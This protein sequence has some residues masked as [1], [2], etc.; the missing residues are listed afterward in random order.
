MKT[1]ILFA[2]LGLITAFGGVHAMAQDDS[3]ITD[4]VVELNETVSD[5]GFVHP[6]VG[7]SAEGLSVMRDMVK[8]GVSPW[9]DYFEGLRQTSYSKLDAP[10]KKQT[11]IENDGGINS[12]CTDAQTAWTQAI[13]YVVTGNEEYRKIPVELI[14]W[15]GE[16][17]DFFPKYFS[18]S[19]IKIGKYVHTMCAA[20]EII[21]YTEPEDESLK[22]TDS[23]IDAL[24]DN[25]ISAIVSGAQ[26][27]NN[28]YFMNQHSYAVQGYLASAVLGDNKD[29]YAD[30]I[31]MTTVNNS[32]TNKPRNGAIDAVI[33][34][35]TE[36]AVTGEAVTPHLQLVEMGRDQAHA[37][38]NT[39]NLLLM[40][41]TADIQ[42]TLVDEDTGLISENGV[43]VR[44]FGGDKIIKG[45]QQWVQFN[46]GYRFE[47]TPVWAENEGDKQVIYRDIADEYRGRLLG[48]SLPS[49]YLSYK[50]LGYDLENDYPYITYAFNK[51]WEADRDRVLSGTYIETLHNYS[52]DFWTNLGKDAAISEPDPERAEK[53]LKTDIEEY[54]GTPSNIIEFENRWIDL[55]ELGTDELSYP[56]G[57]DDKPIEDITEDNREF[58]RV[59]VGNTPRS[60]VI[61]STEGMPKNKIGFMVRSEG[62]AKINIHNGEDYEKYPTIQTINIPDTN[63]EWRYVI[64][65]YSEQAVSDSQR[66]S[67]W[68]F[69]IEGSGAV[70]DFDYINTNEEDIKPIEIITTYPTDVVAA[71][72]GLTITKSHAIDDE[73]VKYHGSG[74]PNGAVIDENTGVLSWTPDAAGEYNISVVA[75][76][77]TSVYMKPVTLSVGDDADA[78]I[79]VICRNYDA[80]TKYV[81][82]TKT[83]YEKALETAKAAPDWANLTALQN[84][85]DSLELLN[86]PLFDGTLDYTDICESTQGTKI[87]I[88]ADGIPQNNASWTEPDMNMI[89]DFGSEFRVRADAF[90][91]QAR[92]SFPARV[93]K[94]NVYGS[95]DMQNWTK[96]TSRDPEI[97]EDMQVIDVVESEKNNTYRYLRIYMPNGLWREDNRAYMADISEFRI[98]GERVEEHTPD[99]NTPFM[100][101]YDDGTFLPENNIT[102]AEAVHMMT[103][104]LPLAF[105]TTGQDNNFKDVPDGAWYRNSA[106][107]M[108]KKK[109]ISADE[110]GNFNPDHMM[111]KQEMKELIEK[112]LGITVEIEVGTENNNVT[113]AEAAKMVVTAQNRPIISTDE[114]VYTDVPSDHWAFDYISEASILHTVERQ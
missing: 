86:P 112:T 82:T 2:L 4:N 13:M 77:G 36:D 101:G 109:F 84:A 78:A 33:R 80:D 76:N 53:A 47:W 114:I 105:D 16:R 95:N 63:G 49:T 15:Y 70:V 10:M 89:M 30:A 87:A 7:A 37:V 113:R 102:R 17:E 42:H 58:T 110:N 98:Y 19:H 18:D 3:I 108:L 52:F 41:R 106:T 75:D 45:A 56:K 43:S 94:M 91:I 22:I 26:L 111:T 50:G 31:E 83:A 73:N 21:R 71:Y 68:M 67:M 25:C 104:L 5:E 79:S 35:V 81:T 107:Y 27:D 12:F 29:A 60:L 46:M 38:G 99:Y 90:G 61:Y 57:D 9:I 97:S 88:Y 1:K 54:A 100:D 39:D 103:K 40:S 23:D 69:E 65:D 64:L 34:D 24:Y 11:K 48:N 6:G 85:A 28:S 66:G 8:Q 51:V 59:T 62:N 72:P 93:W 55:S 96:L 92:T 20:A 44:E 74:L 14:K 32:I